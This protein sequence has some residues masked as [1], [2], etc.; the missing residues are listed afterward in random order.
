MISSYSRREASISLDCE[1]RTTLLPP[2]AGLVAQEP[3]SNTARQRSGN[4]SGQVFGFHGG[5][6][7]AANSGV[8]G[9][10]TFAV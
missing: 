1:E 10:G 7:H 2:V 5:I 8:K 3:S 4:S 6:V 9:Y